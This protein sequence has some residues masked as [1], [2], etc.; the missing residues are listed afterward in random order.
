MSAIFAPFGLYPVLHPSGILRQSVSGQ[1]GVFQGG[2][3]GGGN[4]IASGYAN[5]IFQYSPV[6]IDSQTPSGNVILAPAQGAAGATAAAN[7]IIGAFEGVEF[8]L[9]STG[10]RTVAN[11]WAA[12]TVATNIVAW[13]TRDAMIIYEIQANASVPA[14]ALGGQLSIST[15]GSANGNTTTGFSSVSADFNVI[16]GTS[17][18]QTTTN[19]L[20]IVGFSQRVDNAP[21]DAF[22]ILQVQISGHQDTAQV[23]A[24]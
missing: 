6:Q 13:I 23:A 1:T 12:S 11:F 2:G 9:T 21:G 15:N 7:K 10:R 16:S 3:P 14:T 17:F 18:T 4:S 22:T 20:R 19:Q 24:Y 5:N 8:T